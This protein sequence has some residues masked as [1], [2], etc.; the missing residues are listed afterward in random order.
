MLLDEDQSVLD[1]VGAILR[2]RNHLVRT[3]GTFVEAKSALA[4]REF[5]VVVADLQVAEHADDTGLSAWLKINRPTLLP[6]LV[7]MRSS[8]PPGAGKERVLAVAP[9]LQKPF[10]AGELLAVVESLLTDVH[11]APLER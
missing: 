3:V 2:R 9:I 7:W 10:K 4:Q 5:D 11:S 6:R 1:V 8:T